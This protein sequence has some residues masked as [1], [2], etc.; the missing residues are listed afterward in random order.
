MLRRRSVLA[1]TATVIA[2]CSATAAWGATIQR[3]PLEDGNGDGA[4]GLVV[5]P[6]QQTI[7]VRP[8][9]AASVRI[10]L[11][12]AARRPVQVTAGAITGRGSRDPGSFVDVDP[13][14]HAGDRTRDATSWVS[15]PFERTTLA[16]RTVASFDVAIRAPR[17]ARPGAHPVL[18][19]F[20]IP[21]L[22]TRGDAI[23]V[24]GS[25]GV[26]TT[27]VVTVPGEASASAAIRRADGPGT[28][29]SSNPREHFTIG[30]ENTGDTLLDLDAQIELRSPWGTSRTLPAEHQL[31][32]PGGRRTFRVPFDDPPLVGRFVPTV[33]VVGG[34]DSGVRVTRELEPVW[35]LPPWW[36]WLA[37]ALAVALPVG[38]M[39]RRRRRVRRA[40]AS[41]GS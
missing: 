35:V 40:D 31:A 21:A 11:T 7:G 13:T 39:L 34:K 38:L 19:A 6:P 33:T 36:F 28:I 20:T 14:V 12:N 29:R 37:L 10:Q 4:A 2:A 41:D 27:V 32:L 3:A 30:V 8:G 24:S 18:L 25:G 16:A 23:G 17:D 5:S 15:F 9:G 26:A 22:A 1:L